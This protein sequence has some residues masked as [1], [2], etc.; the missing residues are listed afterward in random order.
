MLATC[1]K[2]NSS[3]V[4]PEK[5][6]YVGVSINGQ[7]SLQNVSLNP[8]IRITFS[9]AVEPSTVTNAVSLKKGAAYVAYTFSL[10]NSNKT[11]LLKPTNTLNAL[12]RYTLTI[13]TALKATPQATLRN[14]QAIGIT[15]GIDSSRKFPLISDAALLDKVQQQ[16]FK[17]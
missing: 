7:P 12:D 8:F 16:T 2:K 15:T 10:E 14:E 5:F 6:D 9:E 17:Y 11:I 3:P 4:Q 13:T 1:G